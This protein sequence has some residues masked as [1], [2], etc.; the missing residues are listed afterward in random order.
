MSSSIL[1]LED[2][3]QDHYGDLNNLYNQHQSV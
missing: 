3:T 2:S 1:N